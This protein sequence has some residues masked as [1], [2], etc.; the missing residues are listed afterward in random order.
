MRRHSTRS[1]EDAE[2]GKILL[3]PS[4]EFHTVHRSGQL[5]VREDEVYR[6]SGAGPF[7]G[8]IGGFCLDYAHAG[9]A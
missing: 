6:D 2:I 7:Q 3:D 1:H 9:T 4:R 5:D 8:L